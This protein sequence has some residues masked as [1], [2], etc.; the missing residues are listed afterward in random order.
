MARK[1]TPTL[2]EAE[3]RIM[4]VIWELGQATVG[5]VVAKLPGKGRLAYN[6]VLTTV[7]ILEHK[8]YLGHVK[9]GRA[10]LYRPLVTRQQARRKAVRHMVSSFFNGS[11]EALM[12]S[13]LQDENLTPEEA[14]R[15][16]KMIE[17][18]EQV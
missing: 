6:T 10:H 15:L 5:D 17:P 16:R 13:I 1:K 2:T 14:D 12:L 18:H 4:D 9:E 3:L 7:R 11:P 8:A